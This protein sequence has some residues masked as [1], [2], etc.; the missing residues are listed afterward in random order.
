MAGYCW[1]QNGDF[2]TVWGG[3][4]ISFATENAKITKNLGLRGWDFGSGRMD[5]GR[6]GGDEDGVVYVKGR[7]ELS[8]KGGKA[9][10][11]FF[12]ADEEIA[13]AEF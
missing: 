5:G 2:S 6:V 3:S 1:C 12:D 10:L 8:F 13:E 11:Q 9:L 7:G 4:V